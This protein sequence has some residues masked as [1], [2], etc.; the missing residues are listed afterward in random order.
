MD[1]KSELVATEIS[2][3]ELEAMD[4]SK[5]VPMVSVPPENVKLDMEQTRFFRE[6]LSRAT[7]TGW[8]GFDDEQ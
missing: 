6:L 4:K 3:V 7:G 5:F 2:Q 8:R 1:E